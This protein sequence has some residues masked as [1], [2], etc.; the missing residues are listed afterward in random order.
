MAGA[1]ASKL[2]PE[3]FAITCSGVETNEIP[4]LAVSVLAEIGFPV[5][6]RYPLSLRAVSSIPFDVVVTLCEEEEREF[7]RC[8]EFPGSPALVHWSVP[9]PFK[10]MKFKDPV[11]IFRS[12]RDEL[13][14][15]TSHLVEDGYLDAIHKQRQIL[16]SL[17]ENLP[18]GV[19]AH[20]S[21][22]RIF[23]FN[24][25]AQKIT[26]YSYAEVIGRDCHEI[27]PGRF[28]GGMC[29]FCEGSIQRE[30]S[31]YSNTFKHKSGELCNFIMSSI[32][33]P[34]IRDEHPSTLVIFRNRK[35]EHLIRPILESSNGFMG[36]IGAS[37]S[38][39]EV[40][41]TIREVSNIN[42]P[43]VITG[44]SGTGKEMVARA[45]HKLSSRSSQPF[46][47][48]NC[49][50]L[51][52][53]TLESEL[54]G[55]V[56]GA[57]TGAIRDKKGRF[58]LAEG[59]TIFLDEIGEVSQAMQIKLLRV[60]EEKS[61]MPVG[62]EKQVSSDVRILSATN[63]NLKV[64]VEQGK[65]RE[66]LYYRLAVVPISL[67]PLRNRT[68]DI[69]VLVNHFMKKY[70]IETGKQILRLSPAAMTALLNYPWPGN[71]REL[72]NTIQYTLIKCHSDMLDL[73]HL[74][75]EIQDSIVLESSRSVGRPTKLEINKV[76]NALKR[77]DGNKA[78]TARLLGVSRP[79][80]YSFLEKHKLS[81]FTQV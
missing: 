78:K 14:H 75:L 48:V 5:T 4:E 68:E 7:N 65:F 59:G 63:R 74:P 41:Q 70:S 66:D 20:D 77:T 76:I 6:A 22:R 9:N 45:I 34:A 21:E 17:I 53:G 60:L 2:F 40:F 71:V 33:L 81:D 15:K 13:Y 26:G 39:D 80:L 16:G 44:E 31:D 18:D 58:E 49:G 38:L 72:S 54:F 35:S 56:R 37:H 36:I 30:K 27:F 32:T 25:S 57:F 64:M 52:E 10:Q 46:V 24:R 3:E 62:G 67:P 29:S 51:P 1:I 12:I 55:H 47:P 42:I 11:E 69:P 8:P 73:E 28:C 23:Y 19:L 61:F 43:V 79:T 50:A